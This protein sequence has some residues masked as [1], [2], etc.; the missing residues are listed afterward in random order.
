[1]YMKNKKFVPVFQEEIKEKLLFSGN[2]NVKLEKRVQFNCREPHSSVA[3]AQ[4]TSF[5]MTKKNQR[6]H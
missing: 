4:Q 1:M 6:K 5:G 2:F 3:I